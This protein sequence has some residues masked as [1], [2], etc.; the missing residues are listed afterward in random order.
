[1]SARYTKVPLPTYRH[2]PGLTTHPNRAP[3]EHAMG[4]PDPAPVSLNE[5]PWQKSESYLYA[6]DLFNAGFW[7]ECHEILEGMWLVT[8][9][10][11]KAGKTMQIII[12]WA[13]A[14]LKIAVD[15][16]LGARR[17]ISQSRQHVAEVG[18]HCLGVDLE[19]MQQ[20]TEDFV[21]GGKEAPAFIVLEFAEN[22]EI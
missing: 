15:H 19:A 16:P 18:H 3:E 1:M 4:K 21:V 7:W 22:S 5:T 11:T 14:H 8:G 20:A 12:Q 9:R 2:L 6:I 13:A 17:L 10:K